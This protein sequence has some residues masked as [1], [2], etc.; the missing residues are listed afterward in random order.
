LVLQDPEPSVLMLGF[1][2]SSL[3]FSIR[4]YVSELAHRLPVTHDIHFR[5]DHAFRENHIEIPFP[6][7][8]LHIRSIV[9]NPAN[10]QIASPYQATSEIP[11]S[12]T[13]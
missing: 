10:G 5:I 3:D 4:V 7:R 9:E 1:G 6:Q 11:I 13:T 2:D 12:Q 8:D